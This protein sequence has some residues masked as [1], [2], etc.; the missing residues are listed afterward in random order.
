MASPALR[1][2]DGD[3]GVVTARGNPMLYREAGT[4]RRQVRRLAAT[5]PMSWLYSHT[6]HHIDRFVYRVTRGRAMFT[7]ALAGLPIILL[8][9]R[10][11]KSG[12][13]VTVP[14]IGLPVD[15]GAIAVVASNWGS[16]RHPGWYHNLF[17][18]PEA[19]VTV[20]GRRMVVRARE[21]TGGEYGRLWQL[22]LAVYPG[23]SAYVRRAA[24]RRIPVMVLASGTADL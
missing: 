18:H 15:D 4:V 8:T 12:R 22:G 6:L 1:V 2:D 17:A 11:A 13:E 9:T 3:A 20:K 14:V 19:T 10:G 24:P 5:A 21:A 16:Q 7:T 23:W